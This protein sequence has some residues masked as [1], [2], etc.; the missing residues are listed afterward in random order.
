MTRG[1]NYNRPGRRWMR[2]NS[3]TAILDAGASTNH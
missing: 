2:A 1:Y 3:T